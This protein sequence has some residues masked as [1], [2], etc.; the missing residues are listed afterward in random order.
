MTTGTILDAILQAKHQRLAVQMQD[1]PL[2][3]L[4]ARIKEMPPPLNLSGALMGGRVRL[5]AEVKKR[6]PSKGLLAT[7]FDPV[8]LATTYAGNGAA[9][10]SVLTETDHFGGSLEHL[11]AVKEA[12]GPKG[13]PVLRK[14]FLDD[15]YQLHE[16]RAWGADAVLLIVAMLTPA[17]LQELLAAAQGL[18]LQ[19]LVEVHNEAELQTALAA[20][21]EI[22]GINHRNL[23]T[24]EVDTS[25]SVRLR[26]L[27]P[28]GKI[29]VAESGIAAA[30]IQPL[31]QAGV[32]AV[33]VGEALMTAPDVAA[34]VRELAGGAT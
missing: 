13:L 31:Q 3:E 20:G 24:F 25:L 30:D 10:I 11:G 21:A 4:E 28:Q 34:K 8:A 22:I 33:L 32:H 7:D 15:P 1:V 26:P 5:I 12:V 17:Q 19:A 16:A 18:W 23:K 2:A 9:A 6:S 27:V 14:D 29:L